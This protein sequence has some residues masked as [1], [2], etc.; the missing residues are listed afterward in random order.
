MPKIK[1]ILVPV[2]FTEYSNRALDFAAQIARPFKAKI[3]LLHVIEQFTYSV[4]DTIQVVDHYPALKTIAEPLLKSLETN[5][6]KKGIAVDSQIQSGRPYMA[7]LEQA[8]KGRPDLI[9]MGTHGRTGV[10][11]LVMGSVAERVVRLA[12]CPVLTVRG[13]PTRAERKEARKGVTLF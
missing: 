10:Q 13:R 3:R 5:L 6:K 12:P 2:D 8:R 9:V 7:I 11:H 4:T 1:R